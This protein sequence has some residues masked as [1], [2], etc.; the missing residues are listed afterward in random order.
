MVAA[1]KHREVGSRGGAFRPRNGV[2]EICAAVC[3]QRG[4]PAA[5]EPAREVAV[6]NSLIEGSRWPIPGLG[7]VGEDAGAGLGQD[8]PRSLRGLRGQ[9]LSRLFGGDGA[10]SWCPA[11]AVAGT[12]DGVVRD[13][14]VKQDV[15][16]LNLASDELDE[17][18]C[19]SLVHR[20]D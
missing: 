5:G 12:A 19:A 3:T 14:D 16:W 2:V 11:G 15:G 7:E 1:A 6:A 10:D 18:I 17:R 9:E 8:A 4:A 13:K 20:A